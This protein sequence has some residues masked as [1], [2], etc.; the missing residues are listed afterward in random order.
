MWLA[1]FLKK[2]ERIIPRCTAIRGRVHFVFINAEVELW[3][4]PYENIGVAKVILRA[5]SASNN[6]YYVITLFLSL[7]QWLCQT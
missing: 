6:H 4:I 7:F 3:G 5:I 2:K 1:L